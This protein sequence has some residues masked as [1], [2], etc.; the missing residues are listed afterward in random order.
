MIVCR[1][2]EQTEKSVIDDSREQSVL[3]EGHFVDKFQ[4]I[5]GLFW[6]VPSHSHILKYRTEVR[7]RDVI[8]IIWVSSF[9]EILNQNNFFVI[10]VGRF[11]ALL[12]KRRIASRRVSHIV[13]RPIRWCLRV[14]QWRQVTCLIRRTSLSCS[15]HSWNILTDLLC[16]LCAFLLA[17]WVVRLHFLLSIIDYAL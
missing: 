2:L 3:K 10:G 13:K 7:F 11:L 1:L 9:I 16:L 15:G 14:L 12:S 8:Q 6:A 5:V 4:L 17:R